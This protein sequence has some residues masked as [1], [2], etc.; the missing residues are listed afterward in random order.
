MERKPTVLVLMQKKYVPRHSPVFC[1]TV[2]WHQQQQNSYRHTA[3][4]WAPVEAVELSLA[5]RY[6]PVLCVTGGSCHD[7]T[8]WELRRLRRGAPDS[9][10]QPACKTRS[11]PDLLAWRHHRQSGLHWFNAPLLGYKWIQPIYAERGPCRL[12]HPAGDSFLLWMGSLQDYDDL[13]LYKA[14]SIR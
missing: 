13:H 6:L 7:T 3:D 2:C 14:V 4:V 10:H 11:P 9:K 1:Q 12:F 5:R 8:G